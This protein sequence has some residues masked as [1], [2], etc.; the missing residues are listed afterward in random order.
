[1]FINNRVVKEID[2][3]PSGARRDAMFAKRMVKII[4]AIDMSRIANVIIEF[5]RTSQRK[6]VMAPTRILHNLDKGQ[7]ILIIIF[8]VKPRHRIGRLHQGAGGGDIQRMLDTPIQ[9]AR[10][11]PL[12]IC[13]LPP[14]NIASLDKVTSFD[15]T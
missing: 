3:H 11:E 13:T 1:M 2:R 6:R 15:K 4:R 14:I 9:L 12:K 7:H 5:R 10:R 8:G